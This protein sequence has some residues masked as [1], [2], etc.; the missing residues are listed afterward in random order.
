MAYSIHNWWNVFCTADED[1]H[2]GK[3]HIW[4]TRCCVHVPLPLPIS[5]FALQNILH[6]TIIPPFNSVCPP[7]QMPHEMNEHQ[8]G[9]IVC[10]WCK[11]VDKTVESLTAVNLCSGRQL[12]HIFEKAGAQDNVAKLRVSIISFKEIFC[13]SNSE[14]HVT[15][16]H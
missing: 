5:W 11:L 1:I 4:H 12:R 8:P 13:Q 3:T 2:N 10:L 15:W 6:F 14:S 7:W 16:L 9:F